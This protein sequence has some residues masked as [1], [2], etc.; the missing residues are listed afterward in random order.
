MKKIFT[1][2]FLI[3]LFFSLNAQDVFFP[4]SYYKT[5]PTLG[6][7]TSS[8]VVVDGNPT[9]WTQEMLIVQG[10][11]NDDARSFRGPH[12]APVYDLYQLY[13]CWDNDN[14]Y[15]MWQITNVAD[16]VCP[17]QGYPNSDNGK[18]W[19][20]NI[21]FQIAFDIDPEKGTDGLISGHTTPGVKDSH[22]WDVY[23]MFSKKEVDKLLM[24]SSKPNV[25]QPGLFSLNATGA[26]DY[27]NVKLFNTVGI[28]YKWGDFCV[29]T[30]IFGINKNQ[31]TGYLITDL[32]NESLYQDFV[33][34]GHNK[35]METVY[36][37]KIPLSALGVTS[38][39]LETTGIGVM[40]IST[41]GQSAVNSLPFDPAT[42]DNASLPYSSDASTS[43][44]KEDVDAFSANFAR[45]GAGA[46][47][48]P[49]PKLTVNPIGGKYI[50]GTSVTLTAEG[51]KTPIKIYYTLDG[52]TPSNLSSLYSNP[53]QITTNNTVLKAVAIDADG[54]SS[55]EATN[56]YITEEPPTPAAI[57][58][59]FKKP[60]NWNS[61][62]LWAWT[63]TNNNLFSSWPGQSLSEIKEGWY[64]YTF[65]PSITNVNVVFSNNGTPQSVDITGITANTCYTKNGELNGKI[66]V[67]ST[68]CPNLTGLNDIKTDYT[69]N[70]FPNPA[71]NFIEVCNNNVNSITIYNLQGIEVK[72]IKNI[73]TNNR[74]DI[75]DLQKGMYIINAGN[76]T[77]AKFIK[78]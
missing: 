48:I 1:L 56:T 38:S 30:Q 78:N 18:P 8:A 5:N 32:T 19:N 54:V 21:P 7:K 70:I 4:S 20:G 63:G 12:E 16:I 9:E 77:S 67:T 59:M 74:V 17:E 3:E 43:K 53:I 14:L 46:V 40:L 45:I 47:V 52:S 26:F 33:S 11:A 31:H 29:P 75:S 28:E 50:G 41:F 55:Y 61:V 62:F 39:Y 27:Q 66:T 34:K 22:V 65:N 69:L 64:S 35:T 73:H 71:K 60:D 15:L 49:R 51:E 72:K 24:F 44:E 6:K 25:G 37:M 23:T 42:I 58:I 76:F 68:D 57:T 2:L 36:E 10:V 13:A